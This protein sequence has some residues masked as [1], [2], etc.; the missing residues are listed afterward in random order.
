MSKGHSFS[1]GGLGAACDVRWIA[2]KT[3]WPFGDTL[4]TRSTMISF[5]RPHPHLFRISAPLRMIQQGEMRTPTRAAQQQIQHCYQSIGSFQP[6]RLTN[7]KRHSHC[8]R[9]RPS[10]KAMKH[11]CG[12]CPLG[13]WCRLHGAPNSLLPNMRSLRARHESHLVHLHLVPNR[14][15]HM[16]AVSRFCAMPT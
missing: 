12:A 14:Q 16:A 1:F 15:V 3:N 10:P 8:P 9:P 6:N 4:G 13:E 7:R 2:A 11:Y 5:R